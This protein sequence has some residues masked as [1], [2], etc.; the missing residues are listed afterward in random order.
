M[1][2]I[3]QQEHMALCANAYSVD[4]KHDS[5][6]ISEGRQDLVLEIKVVNMEIKMGI[7]KEKGGN[8]GQRGQLWPNKE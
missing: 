4:I 2:A 3:N 6:M 5:W 8:N 1:A 7:M